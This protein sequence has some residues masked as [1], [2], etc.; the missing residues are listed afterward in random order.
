MSLYWR[1]SDIDT[2]TLDSPQV[3]DLTPSGQ[4]FQALGTMTMSDR[5]DGKIALI[6]GATSGIG[7]ATAKLFAAQGAHVYITGRNAEALAMAQT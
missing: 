4:T 5:L 1:A 6:T 7:L 3:A 2:P